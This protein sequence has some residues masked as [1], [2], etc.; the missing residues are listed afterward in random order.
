MSNCNCCGKDTFKDNK[1]YFMLTDEVWLTI[2]KD[3]EILCWNCAEE[4]LGR[5]I[6]ANDLNRSFL[7]LFENKVSKKIIQ[8]SG[9]KLNL[10]DIYMFSINMY[11]DEV[12][13]IYQFYHTKR[14]YK[15][16]KQISDHLEISKKIVME[17]EGYDVEDICLCP[18]CIFEDI[19]IFSRL[20]GYERTINEP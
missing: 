10:Y 14:L 20:H 15:F 16:F 8:D 3:D 18:E 17:F 4:K 13:D 2:A 1:D 5:K 19:V 9:Y 11:S 7:T 12:D 6:E